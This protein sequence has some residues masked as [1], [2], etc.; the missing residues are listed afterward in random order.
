[1]TRE[2]AATVIRKQ[3]KAQKQNREEA[4]AATKDI[5]NDQLDIVPN[6]KIVHGELKAKRGREIK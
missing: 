3:C 2:Q 5:L 6:M 1:M 4:T